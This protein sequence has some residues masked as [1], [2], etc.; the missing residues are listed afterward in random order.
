ME[1]FDKV[2]F[3]GP[4]SIL[5]QVVAPALFHLEEHDKQVEYLGVIC[6]VIVTRKPLT[7]YYIVNIADPRIP[8]TGVIGMS[9]LVKPEETAGFHI[10]FLPKYVDSTSPMLKLSDAELQRQFFQGLQLMFPGFENREIESV[11]INR[12]FQVQPLQV[13][14]Y[15]SLVPR[16][17][18]AH[19]DFFVL[20]TSQFTHATLNNNEVVRAVDDFVE[21]Y[22]ER[23][24]AQ[25]SAGAAASIGVPPES[26]AE[27]A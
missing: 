18:S 14:H 4:T 24:A 23:L 8:F 6:M 26:R 1:H 25:P 27:V 9:N 20:N 2:V 3:T 16:V 17:E 19:P 22:A 12:A 13:L 15:S 7:P 5:R 10:T 21:K 11:H